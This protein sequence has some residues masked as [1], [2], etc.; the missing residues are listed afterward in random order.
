[1]RAKATD[2][3][4][5]HGAMIEQNIRALCTERKSLGIVFYVCRK[6]IGQIFEDFFA[7]TVMRIQGRHNVSL[8]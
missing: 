3:V 8:L 6:A 5:L 1:M 4:F 7:K 2:F